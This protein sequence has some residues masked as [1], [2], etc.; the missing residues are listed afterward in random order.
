MV[1]QAQEESLTPM[2]K[3]QEEELENQFFRLDMILDEPTDLFVHFSAC[4]YRDFTRKE[5]AFDFPSG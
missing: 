3:A 2:D 5:V 1:E 4:D